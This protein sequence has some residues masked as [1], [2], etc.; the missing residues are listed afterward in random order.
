[1][2]TPNPP[3]ATQTLPYGAAGIAAAAAL[4]AKGQP[5]AIPTE[6]VYGLAADATDSHAVAR[7]YAAKGARA[8]TR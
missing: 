8:S 3:C 4:I 6:T 7:I 2:T 1:M 5:V